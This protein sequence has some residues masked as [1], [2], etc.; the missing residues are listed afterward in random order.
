MFAGLRRQIHNAGVGGFFE[1]RNGKPRAVE[2]AG[3]VH[4]DAAIP[5]LGVD[6]FNTARWASNARIVHEAIQSVE[7][8][9]SRLKQLCDLASVRHITAGGFHPVQQCRQCGQ[10]RVIDVAHVDASA[11]P[12][13]RPRDLKPDPARARCHQH[14]RILQSKVHG[15]VSA[16]LI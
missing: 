4:G 12:H 5:V 10:R 13:K 11:F 16:G 8:G 3:E 14:A 2:L 7:I 1:M 15:F 6:V 9:H